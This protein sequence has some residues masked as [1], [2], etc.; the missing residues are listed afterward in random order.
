MPDLSCSYLG[1]KLKN[2]LII[3]SSGLTSSLENLKTAS[4]LGAGA[5]VLKSVFEEQIKFETR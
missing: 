1:L 2:P 4:R 3:G 5:V